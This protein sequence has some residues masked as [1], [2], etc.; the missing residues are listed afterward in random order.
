MEGQ[1]K[2]II[3]V[4][5]KQPQ[6][7]SFTWEGETDTFPSSYYTSL[8]THTHTYDFLLPTNTVAQINKG[9]NKLWGACTVTQEP[10]G[11]KHRQCLI[12]LL[13]VNSK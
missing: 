8:V 1:S 13:T 7:D 2:F 3:S 6:W 10:M 9:I 5:V 12:W 11:N 4:D